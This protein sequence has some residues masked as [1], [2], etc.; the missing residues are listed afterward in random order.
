LGKQF[1]QWVADAA[2]PKRTEL[3]NRLPAQMEDFAAWLS[4]LS[5][6]E[7]EQF[8]AQVARYCDSINF[9]VAW[10]TDATVAREPELKQAVEES[11]LLHS[12][13]AWRAGNVQSRAQVALTYQAWLTHPER[14]Q[15]FGQELHK[16]LIERGLVTVPP[17]LYLA[18]EKERLA[19]AATAIRHVAAENPDAFR[20]VLRQLARVPEDT[21]PAGTAAT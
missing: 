9:D 10:L 8:T 12:L 17:E 16:I 1:Q 14:H 11:I 18:P 13:G 3:S 4:G 6:Q 7:L 15:K 20:L 5:A 2:L 21:A 19:Q